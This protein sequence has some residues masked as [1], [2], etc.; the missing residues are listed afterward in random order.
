MVLSARAEEL[1]KSIQRRRTL[2]RV[3]HT[4]FLLATSVSTVTLVII[5]LTLGLESFNFFSQ[6]SIIEFLTSTKWTVLFA[7]KHF[8]ILPLLNATMLTSL[9][10]I[11]VAA[12]LGVMIALYL[13]EY[14]SA[15]TRSIVKPLVETLAGIPTV[16]Y[17]YFA[18]YFLTPSL[19]K[20][21][22]TGVQSHNAL[23]V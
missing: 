12:P 5:Y 6:V 4:I 20:P 16:V 17:G 9:I 18:L 19:L 3:F 23:A 14:A 11:A 8:G 10:A 15:T 1:K 7:D 2:D 22:F 21:L 13:S